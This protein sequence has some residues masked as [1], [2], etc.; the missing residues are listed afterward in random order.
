M[1]PLINGHLY[2]VKTAEVRVAEN[3]GKALHILRGAS[4]TLQ[5]LIHIASCCN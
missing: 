2:V 5:G 4:K 3:F 1:F